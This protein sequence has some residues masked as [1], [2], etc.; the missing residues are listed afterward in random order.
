MASS[1]RRWKLEAA[2]IAYLAFGCGAPDKLVL[3]PYSDFAPLLPDLNQTHREDR[4]SY[5]HVHIDER[6]GQFRLKRKG[7]K[8][9]IDVTH[10]LVP[11]AGE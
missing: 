8:E 10:L 9:P 4:P 7:G 3:F 5:W 6:D 1:G 2:D 11:T